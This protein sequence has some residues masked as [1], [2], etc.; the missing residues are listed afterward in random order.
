MS[1][2]KALGAVA[3][4]GLVAAAIVVPA[5]SAG[6]SVTGVVGLT[7]TANLPSFPTANGAGTCS[8]TSAGLG[9]G[10]TDDGQPFALAGPGTFDASFAYNEECVAGEP[11]VIG[12]A[13]GSAT[14]TGG[15]STEGA[16][17]LNTN[18]NWTRVGLTAVILTSG[19][20]VNFASGRTATA[21]APDAGVAAFA[22]ILG[23]DNVCP[24]GGD[25]TAVV[26]GADVQPL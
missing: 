11:P 18:F 5:G 25:L 6:A 1:V 14:V 21:V 17:T 7:C 24:N 20:N 15:T 23:T 4:A 9:A 8:G 22:P 2:K 3:L 12:F 19:T 16:F 10:L 13:N 26:V